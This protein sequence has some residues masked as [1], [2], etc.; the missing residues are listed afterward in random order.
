MNDRMQELKLS[1]LKTGTRENGLYFVKYSW[2][3]EI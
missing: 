2:K 1:D 3:K